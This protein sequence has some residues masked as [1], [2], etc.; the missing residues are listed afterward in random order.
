MG[1]RFW[2]V[3]QAE[4]KENERIF[5]LPEVRGLMTSLKDRDKDDDVEVVDAALLDERCS[6]L[7][8]LRF[9]VL[10]GIGKKKK[11]MKAFV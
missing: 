3:T 2:P 11:A 6:F 10:L 7:G 8:R 4:K 5:K 9:A 1:K